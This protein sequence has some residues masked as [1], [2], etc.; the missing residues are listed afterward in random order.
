MFRVTRPQIRHYTVAGLSVASITLLTQL[1]LPLIK[2][3]IVILFLAAVAFSVWYGGFE[4]GLLATLLST[5]AIAYFFI[6]PNYSLTITWEVMLRL[7][8]FWL[9]ALLICSLSAELRTA[10]QRTEE[11]LAKLKASEEQYRRIVETANEAI[12]LVNAEWRTEYVNQRMA[13]MFGYSIEEMLGRSI[14][15][16]MDTSARLE[17]QQQIDRRQEGIKERFHF[18]YRRKDG[19]DLWAFVSA[20]PILDERGNFTGRLAML[21]DVTEHQQAQKELQESEK[22]H[23]AFVEQ[24][25]EGIWCFE[26]EQPI[27]IESSA[28]EQIQLFYQYGYLAECNDIMAQMYGFSVAQDII[29]LRLNDF[30]PRSDDHNIEYLRAFIGSGY[31]LIDA[32]S[33]EV[34]SNGN[35]KHFLNN[36]VGTVENG[37][38]VRAWGTQRDIT[39][40]KRLVEELQESE[41]RF[42]IMADTAPVLIW[43]SGLDKLYYYFNKVWLD[44][45][46]RTMEE[47]A[48]NGWAEGVHPDDFQH[49][50]DTYMTAFDARQSFQ[51]EYRLKRFDGEYRWLLDTGIPRLTPDGSFLGYIGSC[52]DITERKQAEDALRE[53]EEQTRLIADSLPTLIAYIDSQERYLFNNKTYETWFSNELTEITGKSVKDVLGEAVYGEVR[54]YIELALSGQTVSYETAIPYKNWERYVRVNYVPHLGGRGEVQGFVALVSDISDHH[55]NEEKIR[56]LN[57]ELQRRITELETLLRV[58]PIGIGMA[59]DAQC[60]RLKVN[61]YLAKWLRISHETASLSALVEPKSRQFKAYKSGREQAT[62]QLPMQYCAANGVEVLDEEIEVFHENG[63]I[64]K[65]LVSAAP[66]FDEDGNSRGCVAAFSDITE[67]KRN[68]EELQ[69]LIKDLSDIKFAIDQAALVVVTDSKG[70]INYVNDKFCEISQYSQEELIGKTH[71]LVNS[72]Y[73]PKEFFQQLWS[74]ISSGKVWQGEIK[75]KAKDGTYY[76]VDTT[77]V[78]FLNDQGTPFQYLA[79]RFDISQR[80]RVEEA[81]NFLAGA[82]TVLASSLDYS[83][84]LTSVAQ[85]AV[86]HMA[87]WCSVHVLKENGSIEPLAVAHANP[88]KVEWANE[89]RYRYPVDPSEERG[90]AQVLRTGKSELYSDI[91]DYLL[92][93]SARTPEHLEILRQVGLASVM[94]VPMVARDKTLGTI[95]FIAAESGRRYTPSDLIFAED[96]AY[97]AALAVDNAKLYSSAVEHRTQAELAN[98]V[99]DEFLATL[100]HELR[101][102][103]TSILGWAKLLRSR[104]FDQTTTERA[105]ETIERNAKS[106]SQLIE[107]LLDVSRIITGQ[108]RLNVRQVALHTVVEAA[109]DAVRPAAE[110]KSIRLQPVLDPSAGPVA[111]DPE[112][113]QQ[114]IWNLLSN[115]IKFTPKEGVVQIFLERINSHV[116]I[117]VSDTGMGI[118]AEFLPFVFERF[119]QADA[120]SSRVHGGLGLGLAIVRHLVEL[121]GGTVSVT[122]PGEQQGSTFTVKLPLMIIHKKFTSSQR[123]HP[124]TGGET[125]LDSSG[126][127]ADLKVLVVDD[128]TDARELIKMILEEYGAKVTAVPSAAEGLLTLQ[129]LKP[130]V[131]VSDIEMPGE[132]GYTFIRQVRGLEAS[133]GGRVPAAALTAYARVEDRQRALWAGFQMH[134][135]KPVEPA[136]LVAVVANLAGRTRNG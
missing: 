73:H 128:A 4:A 133:Q 43:M 67:R 86:P 26:L 88:A 92:V 44:F 91:P 93:A 132:D 78:P 54:P 19:S 105:L 64:I 121:H 8:I 65:L 114:V 70:V 18:C 46:G 111:G 71:R 94:I 60:Q 16:F 112:R 89:L 35:P 12:W 58:I 40:R 116:E 45:T 55:Q 110:A 108:L 9:V 37:F 117:T 29:G 32:E 57:K 136:E 109:L 124:T 102:P 59:E 53:S 22:R 25:S 66:L 47:E 72:G 100:S 101:T 98:R 130:D 56:N 7:G 123:L 34:D 61:P 95:S 36:L 6:S 118:K 79:I 104:T 10:K 39:E 90:V 14:F 52:V 85:L 126:V 49:C 84:T 63:T 13:E 97:R 103:L 68:E 80:K 125:S 77:I 76:W 20:N 38:V 83:T 2:P 82:S 75:N 131:L 15:D 134:V 23:R 27:S 69:S 99:K 122:S 106:Q 129:Q 74:T 24:S 127:L 11:N 31:R 17:A 28:D 51:M 48:G 113:L 3:N 135:T 115:A 81:Q 120:S 50:L 62:E 41:N 21:V 33:H 119:S 107:D 87:D 5:L 96:L 42:Q 30:I 1:L